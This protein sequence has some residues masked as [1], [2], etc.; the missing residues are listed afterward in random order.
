M[1]KT[2]KAVFRVRIRGTLEAVW[3][4][5]TKTD[6]RQACMFNARMHTDGLAPGG[7]IRMR[8]ESG[9]FTSVVGEVLVF[10][11][12]RR[13]SH[14]M[15]FTA[16]DDPPCIVTYQLNE[17]EA[18]VVEFTLTCENIPSGTKTAKDMKRG[19]NMI[20]KTLKVVVETGRP[21]LATR[22][23]YVFFGLMEPVM[24]KRARSENWPLDRRAEE[25]PQGRAS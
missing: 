3:R 19:G 4:E 16:Y 18:G 17:V 13:F 1:A 20:V 15:R 6:E 22:L 24:P 21:T 25:L 5:I 2:E 11:P 9:K 14:T 12:P 10:E 23:L 7:Q 8:T